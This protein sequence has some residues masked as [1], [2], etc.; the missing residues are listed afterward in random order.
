VNG[1]AAIVTVP[2][3]R[4]FDKGLIFVKETDILLSGNKW[5]IVV[6]IALNDYANLVENKLILGQMHQKI[7]VDGSSK[8]HSFDVHWEETD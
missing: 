6:N 5:T 2:E 8:L 7:Q 1:V 4:T 3:P